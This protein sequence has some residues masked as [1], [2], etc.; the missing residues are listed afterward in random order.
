MKS[1]IR[2]LLAAIILPAFGLFAIN[3]QADFIDLFVDGFQ[4]VS[5]VTDG[6]EGDDPENFDEV[7][8][9][10]ATILGG[11]RDI[12]VDVISGGVDNNGNNRCNVGDACTTMTVSNGSLTFNNDTGV[13]GIGIVQWD[14]DDDSSNLTIDSSAT[15]FHEDFVNQEGCG[16]GC[17]RFEV[18]VLAA[19]QGFVFTIG[20][21]TDA[22]HWTE[23]DLVSSGDTG[24]Q[25]FLFSDFENLALCGA[26][27][28][29]VPGIEAMRCGGGGTVDFNDVN[30]MQLILNVDG[31]TVAV[32]L[33]IGAVT[34][35]PEP[36]V[37][38]LLGLGLAAGG[39]LR[40][41]RRSPKL[42][43]IS[44]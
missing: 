13:A 14:G 30:A 24:I 26:D 20:I 23:F 1:Y 25:T 38:A 18:E 35:V 34:K 29:G 10:P 44:A 16:V 21:Y 22:T 36:G 19:D 2:S 33:R 42:R 40:R 28:S 17:D 12:K 11:F 4:S 6:L 8:D 7:G 9:F 43:S 41:R 15:G 3:A 31:G 27:F 39:L 32:D 37:L 5:D